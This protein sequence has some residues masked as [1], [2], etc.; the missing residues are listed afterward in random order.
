MVAGS[1]MLLGLTLFGL[2]FCSDSYQRAK[3]SK[4]EDI[5]HGTHCLSAWDGSHAA[6]K[7]AVKRQMRDPKSFKHIE[8]EIGPLMPSGRHRILMTYSARNGF[9]GLTS[10]TATG[11]FRNS[12][13][14]HTILSIE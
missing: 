9:G 8:T 1:I 13:C 5:R 4:V 2:S 10:G 11:E 6:F 14:R 12:G 7:D 3:A